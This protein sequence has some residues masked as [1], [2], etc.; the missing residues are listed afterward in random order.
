[1]KAALPPAGAVTE[2][3]IF[4]IVNA[5]CVPLPVPVPVPVPV[6]AISLSETKIQLLGLVKLLAKVR[7]PRPS[8]NWAISITQDVPLL[9]AIENGALTPAATTMLPSVP[10]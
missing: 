6:V 5:C 10:T 4:I 8:P 7:R 2:V 1:M 3:T 9:A